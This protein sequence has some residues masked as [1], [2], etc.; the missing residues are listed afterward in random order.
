MA[1]IKG[2]KSTSNGMKVSFGAKKKGKYK[3]HVNKH[4]NTEKKYIG[5]GR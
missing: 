5:Q 1:K 3:K 2:N 4:E